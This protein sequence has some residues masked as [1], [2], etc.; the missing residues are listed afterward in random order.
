MLPYQSCN[1]SA[2]NQGETVQNSLDWE[3]VPK[4][5]DN[6]LTEGATL[7]TWYLKTTVDVTIMLHIILKKNNYASDYKGNHMMWN[8]R[9]GL[10]ILKKDERWKKWQTIN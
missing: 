4:C 5:F 7:L 3:K 2:C 9:G 1:L 6:D 8:K 10:Q